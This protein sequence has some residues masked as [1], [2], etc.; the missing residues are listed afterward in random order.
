[1]PSIK[2]QSRLLW[3]ERR[4]C[5]PALTRP[6]GSALGTGFIPL[7]RQAGCAAAGWQGGAA[8]SQN[9]GCGV[10]RVSESAGWTA[11]VATAPVHPHTA[12]CETYCLL[13]G[14]AGQLCPWNEGRPQKAL[15]QIV[16]LVLV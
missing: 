10:P 16:A 13:L 6:P 1:M 7:K 11:C 12:M 15:I 3:L 5:S 9:G 14:M 4:A 2:I 8:G